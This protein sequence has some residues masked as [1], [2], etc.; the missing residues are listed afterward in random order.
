[1]AKLLPNRPELALLRGKRTPEALA[2]W[3]RVFGGDD[4]VLTRRY[5]D[6]V[7]AFLGSASDE[8]AA[9]AGTLAPATR[10]AYAFAVTEFFEWLAT[11]RSRI[12]PPHEV[13]RQDAQDYTN[14]LATKPFTLTEEKLRDG[15]QELRLRIFGAVRKLGSADRRS[16]LAML[17]EPEMDLP[18][19]SHELGR[20]VLHD[21]LVRSPTMEELRKI[22]PR[23]GI[24]LFEMDDT[25]IGDLFIYQTPPPV[26]VGRSTIL[27]RLAG[28]VAFWDVLAQGEN[29]DDGG[30]I[31]RYNI[32]RQVRERVSRGS[33]T[34]RSA[35][36]ASQRMEPALV[37]R[38]LDAAEGD[39]LIELRDLAL[40]TFL[41]FSGARISECISLRRSPPPASE[42][43]R[44]RGWLDPYTEPATVHVRRKGNK[45]ARIPYPP[46]AMAALS[47][48]HAELKSKGGNGQGQ[49][50][51]LYN[52]AHMPDAPLFPPVEL[53]GANSERNY[54]E[55][56]PNANHDYRKGLSRPGAN[57]ALK[58]MG[59]RAGFTDA[60]LKQVHP[61]ALR[62]FAA[63]AMVEGG[64][65]LRQ[66]QAILGHSSV[67]TTEGYLPGPV[68]PVALSGQAEILA[69]LAR[70]RAPAAA[71]APPPEPARTRAPEP[72]RAR[73]R[74]GRVVTTVAV[75]VFEDETFE[76]PQEESAP[77][78]QQELAAIAAAA[79]PPERSLPHGVFRRGE[80][81]RAVA[82]EDP[83]DLPPNVLPEAPP[84]PRH[85]LDIIP[86]AEGPA[87]VE[88]GR[89]IAIDGKA[90]TPTQAGIAT[91]IRGGVSP[92]SPFWVYDA[93]SS[94]DDTERIEFTMLTNRKPS[95]RHLVTIE[96]TKGGADRVQLRTEPSS[97]NRAGHDFLATFYDPWPN[98][99]GLGTV[100]L[101]P[102]FAKGSADLTGGVKGTDPVTGA[103]IS[104]PPLPVLAPEQIAPQMRVGDSPTFLDRL[105]ALYGEWVEGTPDS[106]P[107]PGRT[108]GLV[109]W[110][111]FFAYTTAKLDTFLRLKRAETAAGFLPRWVPFSNA[112]E[113]SKDLRA[114]DDD[115]VI[116][117]FRQNAHT[118]V[119]AV[120]TMRAMVPRGR[121]EGHSQQEFYQHFER[122]SAEGV[123]FTEKLPE[124]LIETDP[125]RAIYDR[126][127]EEFAEF[128]RWLA[129]LTGQ[130]LDKLRQDGRDDAISFA[131]DKALERRAEIRNLYEQYVDIPSRLAIIG[132]R[133]SG[134]LRGALPDEYAEYEF[135]TEKELRAEQKGLNEYKTLL[136]ERLKSLDA[137]DPGTVDDLPHRM[138]DRID[139]L[140]KLAGGDVVNASDGNLLGKSSLF[141]PRLFSVDH[142]NKTIRHTPEYSEVF[143]ERF[144]G[145]DSELIMRR[146]A[147]AMWESAR[148]GSK[149]KSMLYA[150][151]LTY[152]SWV[153][154]T[155]ADM[156]VQAGAFE[157]AQ[158]T[159]PKEARKAWLVTQAEM[160]ARLARDPSLGQLTDTQRRD[161]LASQAGTNEEAADVA[162]QLDDLTSVLNSELERW[163]SDESAAAEIAA[164]V[165]EGGWMRAYVPRAAAE[166]SRKAEREEERSLSGPVRQLMK[167]GELLPEASERSLPAGVIRRGGRPAIADHAD[168]AAEERVMLTPNQRGDLFEALAG[169]KPSVW[170]LLRRGAY[171]PNGPR[172]FVSGRAA[173]RRGRL[174]ANASQVLPSPL[175]ILGALALTQ[176]LD[177]GGRAST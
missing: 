167:S 151:M 153:I 175:R 22:E 72:A 120:R 124:W 119:T 141:D 93:L 44:W 135:S 35:A 128:T 157:R 176:D 117:W 156:E 71:A 85:A 166:K 56:K 30:A 96:K 108:Y 101:L 25:P 29:T 115:W 100:S 155:P 132:R 23:L 54:T 164:A 53:W 50:E 154:P 76:L 78:P 165:S 81:R 116:D 69:Y 127:P 173:G 74:G 118:Y 58:R 143:A 21:L 41:L 103:V 45:V 5:T 65:D 148:S 4:A 36:S 110:F 10:R 158:P 145:R 14:W 137:P 63:T 47:R 52:L 19:L 99:Y 80:R 49:R 51:R 64:K 87:V 3:M 37:P 133:L 2:D 163:Q 146:A 107:S 95:E 174:L 8:L 149:D 59:R 17:A 171:T 92:G 91:E 15:D 46:I 126:D 160:L 161:I 89:L 98:N 20:M 61:H 18:A 123:S 152:I 39:T 136:V 102:W 138:S 55:Y 32:F 62:H 7:G 97:K 84:A 67:T 66:V 134:A 82:I 144:D 33:A 9:Y 130:S 129:N 40:L 150:T 86:T 111:S 168:L 140:M 11:A 57:A 28:L 12:V 122:A 43:A 68:G 77:T 48:F 6:A 169:E 60:E 27:Q 147:R 75:P 79:T 34:E 1:M 73:D 42:Q 159:A 104:I 16:I 70:L 105:D 13:L 131:E 83:A 172:H 177:V 26:P 24:D 162:L 121:G 31:V 142:R 112:A 109:R 139:H 88:E 170:F 113:V 90:P 106:P 125:V 38:L 114:H 94:G